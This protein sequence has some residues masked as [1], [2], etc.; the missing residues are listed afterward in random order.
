MTEEEIEMEFRNL[1]ITAMKNLDIDNLE[2]FMEYI[3]DRAEI[4]LYS[5]RRAKQI[6]EEVL[7]IMEGFHDEC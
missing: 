1:I 2:S 6:Q 3:R 7:Q 4:Q 5:I